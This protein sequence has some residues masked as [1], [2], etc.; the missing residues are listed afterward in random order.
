MA[1][2]FAAELDYEAFRDDTRTV[3]AVVRRLEK[4][5]FGPQRVSKGVP[6]GTLTG[7]ST[8]DKGASVSHP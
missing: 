8:L 4:R 3:Y 6:C 7:V 1:A 2:Q 5:V